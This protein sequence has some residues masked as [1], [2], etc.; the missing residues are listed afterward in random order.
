MTKEEFEKLTDE[1][2]KQVYNEY[3]RMKKMIENNYE[4]SLEE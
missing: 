1:K 2:K 4:K 3:L